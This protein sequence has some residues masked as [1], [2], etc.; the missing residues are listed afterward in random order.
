M[1]YPTTPRRSRARYATVAAV[2]VAAAFLTQIVTVTTHGLLMGDFHAFFCGA[3]ALVHGQN[4]YLSEPLRACESAPVPS[5]F[6][7]LSGH[8]VVIPAPLPPYALALFM[9]FALLP[10][11]LA[12]ALWMLLSLLACGVCARAVAQLTGVERSD[13]W[14]LFAFAL[15]SM[16][17]PY[18]ELVPVVLA[19]LCSAALAIERGAVRRAAA[20]CALAA[21]EP[22]VALPAF[23]ALLLWRPASRLWLVLAGLVFAVLSGA[24]LGMSAT[25]SYF[26]S[27]LP[28]QALAELP[29]D[30]Q[31]SLAWVLWRLGVNDTLALRIGTLSYVVMFVVGIIGARS[32]ERRWRQPAVLVLL[33][34]AAVL[35]GGAFIHIVQMAVALPFVALAL[36]HVERGRWA[37][38]LSL[39]L[40]ALPFQAV[41]TAPWSLFLAAALCGWLVWRFVRADAML[42]LR[43]ALGIVVLDAAAMAALVIWRTPT[44][45]ALVA[46]AIDPS[47]PQASWAAL[48]RAQASG[49]PA[50]WLFKLPTWIALLAA[51]YG[52][53][54]SRKSS[55]TPAAWNNQSQ[56]P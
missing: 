39:L 44:P 31:F 38:Q 17:V 49:T 18:G 29:R 20:W 25:I 46:P 23:C 1:A 19:A 5:I 22:H 43:C 28:L 2:L 27:V 4:P 56:Q 9:P 37:L 21:I 50:A 8:A 16:S 47:L 54:A 26:T 6:Q 48:I 41:G 30:T 13:G 14:A 36:L 51:G 53:V 35:L 12:A 34:P 45:P 7:R 11:P 33:P 24:V 10:Y 15:V 40:L 52:L 55:L 32:L 3:Y 42:A